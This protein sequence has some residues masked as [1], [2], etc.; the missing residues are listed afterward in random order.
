MK[1]KKKAWVGAE[2]GKESGVV[3]STLLARTFCINQLSKKLEGGV[4]I[5][6]AQKQL[7]N[8]DME[9]RFRCFARIWELGFWL[10]AGLLFGGDFLAYPVHRRPAVKPCESMKITTRML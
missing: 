3:S 8:T 2:R 7:I 1:K 10:T 5:F 6:V 9:S 4:A